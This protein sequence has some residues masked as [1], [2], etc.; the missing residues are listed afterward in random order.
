VRGT[1]VVRSVFF[2]GS[3]RARPRYVTIGSQW[4][5]QSGSQPQIGTAFVRYHVDAARRRQRQQCIDHH[6]MIVLRGTV[7]QSKH[8]DV[9]DR[10]HYFFFLRFFFLFCLFGL[11]GLFVSFVVSLVVWFLPVVEREVKKCEAKERKK[12][13]PATERSE[14]EGSR[15]NGKKENEIRYKKMIRWRPIRRWTSAVDNDSRMVVLFT[16]MSKNLAS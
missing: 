10:W 11:F 5:R 9:L 13:T 7:V 4:M 6:P 15:R 12:S 14:G 3:E 16:A 1:G 2:D 8:D